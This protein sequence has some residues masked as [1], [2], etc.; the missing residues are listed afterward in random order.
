MPAD[1]L[2][3][4]LDRLARYKQWKGKFLL[5]AL[6]KCCVKWA[7]SPDSF[8]ASSRAE[9]TLGPADLYVNEEGDG[10]NARQR[11][12]MAYLLKNEASVAA[13]LLDIIKA[14]LDRYLPDLIRTH[15]WKPHEIEAR[16]CFFEKLKTGNGIC[17]IVSLLSLFIY[18]RQFAGCSYTGFVFEQ[19]WDP[20]HNFIVI[21]H[22]NR[23]VDSGD[24]GAL[25]NFEE[26]ERYENEGDPVY[27]Y[28]G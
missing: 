27:G 22:K 5:P 17:E 15:D 10:P 24:H 25:S 6:A 23:V 21:M 16:D 4:P 20:E 8:Y 9:R 1:D 19:G 18:Q 13:T 11:A 14:E 26:S 12:A 7:W 28:Y 2:F 3:P